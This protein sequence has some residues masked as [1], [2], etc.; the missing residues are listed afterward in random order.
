MYCVKCGKPLPKDA[1]FCG[2]CGNK[3]P[4]GF[5]IF[6]LDVVSDKNINS[7]NDKDDKRLWKVKQILF[8]TVIMM[9]VIVGIVVAIGATNHRNATGQGKSDEYESASVS[10]AESS[11]YYMEPQAEDTN[12]DESQIESNNLSDVQIDPINGFYEIPDII[13][14]GKRITYGKTS[15]EEILKM[16][17]YKDIGATIGAHRV[18]IDL[19]VD[20]N[21]DSNSWNIL[22]RLT[23][24]SREEADSSASSS[25]IVKDFNKYTD[26]QSAPFMIY[27]QGQKM[28]TK[29][30]ELSNGIGFSSDLQDV[31]NLYGGIDEKKIWDNS[32]FCYLCDNWGD[33]SIQ[34][35]YWCD[36]L[37]VDVRYA[38]Y[39]DF[40]IFDITNNRN[41]L[42][43]FNDE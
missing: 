6:K 24:K 31:I 28:D 32:N 10:N 3:V 22:L 11:Y 35:E 14:D 4:E 42:G 1:I 29:L 17:N 26:I 37:Q 5:E 9:I 36:K 13:C 19:V 27:V 25:E 38:F 34:Y 21:D 20:D 16:V 30:V 18:V 15:L 39:P 41:V 23:M 8:V 43:G 40:I 7:T 12:I 2:K 33:N